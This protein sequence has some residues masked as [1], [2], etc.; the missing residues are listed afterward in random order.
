MRK[1][2]VGL[3]VA[4]LLAAPIP[5]AGSSAGATRQTERNAVANPGARSAASLLVRRFNASNCR[6]DRWGSDPCGRRSYGVLAGKFVRIALQGSGGM[7]IKFRIFS[8]RTGNEL[9][10][11]D[12]NAG[13]RKTIWTNTTGH[14]V[15]VRFTAD[16]SGLVNTIATGKFL[17]GLYP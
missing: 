15:N 12:L 16:A 10:E 13:D 7:R 3:A 4:G 8:T 5:A 6:I 17:F 11:K 1:I 9:G 14:R 2:T